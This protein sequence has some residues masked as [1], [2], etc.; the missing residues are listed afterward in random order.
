MNESHLFKKIVKIKL[1]KMFRQ[2]FLQKLQDF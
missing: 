1:T 2:T